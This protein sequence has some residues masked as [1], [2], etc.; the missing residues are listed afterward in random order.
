MSSIREALVALGAESC[1]HAGLWADRYLPAHPPDR[2]DRKA[3]EVFIEQVSAIH[4]PTFYPP[5]FDR[6]VA[7]LAER[8]AL[9]YRARTP[10]RIVAG[11]GRSSVIETG[12]TIHHTYGVPII[13]GSSLKGAAAAYSR[14]HGDT[15]WQ[16]SGSAYETVFGAMS[17]AG[18]VTFLDALPVPGT[19]KLLSDVMTVHHRDYYGGTGDAPA[20]WDDPTPVQYLSVRGTFVI[21]VLAQ[22]GAT[23]WAEQALGILKLALSQT[24]VGGKTS[25]GYGRLEQVVPVA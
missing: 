24:G 1:Q 10:Y 12:L 7:E 16:Q 20:D 8:E 22:A 19:W 11:L 3:Y 2:K 25:S 13:P 21:A 15:N 18:Y 17:G 5:L 4:Q 14:E 6:W 9:T 23:D